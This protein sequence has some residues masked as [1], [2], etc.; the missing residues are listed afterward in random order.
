MIVSVADGE[1]CEAVL[2]SMREQGATAVAIKS[3][4]P[5]QDGISFRYVKGC[6]FVAI[7]VIQRYIHMNLVVQ[8]GS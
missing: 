7:K 1:G 4:E 5:R 8:V 6:T 3:G 2:M